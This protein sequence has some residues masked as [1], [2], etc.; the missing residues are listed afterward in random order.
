MNIVWFLDTTYLMARGEYEAKQLLVEEEIERLQMKKKGY[1]S[2][3]LEVSFL[4]GGMTEITVDSAAEESVCPWSWG[5]QFGVKD[6]EEW[7]KFSS[8]NGG[9]IAHRGQR[10]V[11]FESTF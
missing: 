8:A 11:K 5:A 6:A 2:Y 7:M 3:V 10:L 9:N 1:G 4:G